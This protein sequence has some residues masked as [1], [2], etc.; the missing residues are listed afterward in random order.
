MDDFTSEAL[1]AHMG[2]LQLLQLRIVLHHI[3]VGVRLRLSSLRHLRV[4]P[5]AWL[6]RFSWSAWRW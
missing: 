5:T 4:N 6:F 1:T 2:I 3:K